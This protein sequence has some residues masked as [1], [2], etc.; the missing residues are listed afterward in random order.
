MR[1]GADHTADQMSCPDRARAAAAAPTLGPPALRC[2]KPLK[3]FQK[4]N[5]QPTLSHSEA[6]GINS[7]ASGTLALLLA[8]VTSTQCRP[9]HADKHSEGP[10]TRIR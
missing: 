1:A 10:C 8:R 9:F 7:E 4:A 2:L 5:R 3:I 6:S